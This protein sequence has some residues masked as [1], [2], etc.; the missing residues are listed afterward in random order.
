MEVRDKKVSRIKEE[1]HQ[2]T[3]G[4]RVLGGLEAQSGWGV[5]RSTNH[6]QGRPN[7]SVGEGFWS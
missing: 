7:W 5:W 1:E 4:E 3:R 6:F 2:L